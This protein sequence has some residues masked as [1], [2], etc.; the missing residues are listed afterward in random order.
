MNPICSKCNQESEL[1]TGLEIYPRRPDL[2]SKKFFRCPTHTDMYVGTHVKTE[3]P[4]G[5]LADAEHRLL[6]MKCH[7]EFDKHW[8]E[9]GSDIGRRQKRFRC[10]AKLAE[11]MN[12]TIDQTHFGMFTPT[13]CRVALDKIKKWDKI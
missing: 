9:A 4:L 13:Q 6:K 5:I 2:Y 10:Y 8:L 3:E 12:L 7:A 1:V 11:E